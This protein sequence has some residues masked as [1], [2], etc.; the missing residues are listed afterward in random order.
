MRTTLI[1]ITA[2]GLLCPGPLSVF[3]QNCTPAPAGLVS[4]WKGDGNALDSVGTNYGVIFDGI[5]FTNAEVGKGFVISG[6]GDDYVELPTNLFPVPTTGTGNAPFTFEVWFKTASGGV[7]LGQQ[8]AHPFN[9]V[10]GNV[11]GLYV[12]TNGLLYAQMF[13]NAFIQ[14]ATTNAVNDNR[15][16]HAAVTYDGA[17]EILYLDGAAKVSVPYVQQAYATTYY[18]QLG[19]GWSDGWDDTPGG[20]Y[21]FAGII[22]EASFYNRALTPVEVAEIYSAGSS[23]KCAP[24]MGPA[25]LH[26]YSFNSKVGS[27]SVVDSSSGAN[28]QLFFFSS[29]APYT[30]GAPDGS[31]FTGT[32]QLSLGG[33]NGYVLLPPGLIS[34]LSNLTVEAWITWN[35][36]STSVWQRICDFGF[37]D[38][39]TNASGTGTNYMILCPARG[40]TDL[41]GFEETTVNPF[42]SIQ[43]TNSLIL[44]A[45]TSLPVGQ[46]VFLAA[47]YDPLGGTSQFFVNG[48]M[49]NAASG[50]FNALQKFADYNNWLG[51]SQWERDPFFNGAYDEFR[52]WEGILSPQDIA[53][54]YAGGPDELFLTR[55]LLSIARL[56]ANVVL[57]WPTNQNAV[58]GLQASA[59]LSPVNWL[60]VTN[61]V[62]VSNS[63]FQVTLPV[64]GART[65]Y[66]LSH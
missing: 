24:V 18:Y 62:T 17:Q 8:D 3:A 63:V 44:M 39:G 53:R 22:D 41:P 38:R 36:P 56:G 27:R 25:L 45:D 29:T 12:A 23:G 59:G 65:F 37:S 19:T 13:W 11:P 33:T 16:H 47:T 10:S 20:W 1:G 50:T 40:G 14:L 42:G 7:I 4:W 30:N 26:R 49:V 64:Q 32:G 5:T 2:L 15:F 55:P 28:G 48:R 21:P 61:A 43:D 51:R 31:G 57:S 60:A 9:T 34:S 52:I 46:E 66:R 58:F 35:G 6:S 54:H